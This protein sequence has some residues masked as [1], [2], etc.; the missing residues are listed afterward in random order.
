MAF[1]VA[2]IRDGRGT[3]LEFAPSLGLEPSS[4]LINS[5]APSPGRLT[6]TKCRP[7]DSN[8]DCAGFEPAASAGWARTTLVLSEGVEPSIPKA[9]VSKTSV[10]ASS[11]TRALVGKRGLE[12]WWSASEAGGATHNPNFPLVTD[13]GIE[14]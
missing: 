9:L 14:P 11:T 3:V 10:Y 6:G 12:T 8:R 5:Q 1:T 13:Y 2:I 4:F 7:S